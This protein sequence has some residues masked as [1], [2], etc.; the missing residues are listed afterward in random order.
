MA[1][2]IPDGLHRPGNDGPRFHNPTSILSSSGIRAPGLGVACGTSRWGPPAAGRN[3]GLRPP[4]ARRA[5]CAALDAPS[6]AL[7]VHQQGGAAS[8]EPRG[9]PELRA[10]H[11]ASRWSRS[12]AGRVG[13]RRSPRLMSW[14]PYRPRT[15]RWL[16]PAAGRRWRRR[17]PRSMPSAWMPPASLASSRRSA[18]LIS[19]TMR[20]AISI[21]E[22]QSRD[23]DRPHP[24]KWIYRRR[25][26]LNRFAPAV[27]A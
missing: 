16:P 2:W 24:R 11:R 19:L 14:A 17:S 23:E 12:A 18:A 4:A 27:S 13:R 3:G 6:G 22:R 26:G 1:T 25:I 9:C 20:K 10:A 5:R 21:R 8:C 7:P 15:C